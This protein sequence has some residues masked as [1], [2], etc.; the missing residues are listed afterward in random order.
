VGDVRDETALERD[1][2][3]AAPTVPPLPAIGSTK[4]SATTSATREVRGGALEPRHD[5]TGAMRSHPGI[6]DARSR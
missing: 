6:P 3:A 2:A 5:A 4:A 1:H